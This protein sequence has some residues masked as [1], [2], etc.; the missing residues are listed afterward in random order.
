MI[1]IIYHIPYIIHK[2][3]AYQISIYHIIYILNII[4]RMYIYT[5]FSTRSFQSTRNVRS[6]KNQGN[7]IPVCRSP[8]PKVLSMIIDKCFSFGFFSK[9]NS[10][11]RCSSYIWHHEYYW[12]GL[13]SISGYLLEEDMDKGVKK[14]ENQW[15]N[16]K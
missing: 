5:L 12:G 14:C 9:G 3:I 16:G 11:P 2:Y 10:S 4:F 8:H 7:G 13:V 1:Y 15:K 6:F